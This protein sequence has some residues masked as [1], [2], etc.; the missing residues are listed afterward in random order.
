MATVFSNIAAMSS[1][2]STTECSVKCRGRVLHDE[3]RRL[4]VGDVVVPAL[5]DGDA[6]EQVVAAV[7]RLAELQDVA[8]AGQLDAELLADGAGAAVAAD[9]V[10]RG[11]RS[12]SCRASLISAV[13]DWASCSND[14]N[15]QP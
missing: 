15:S 5:A 1:S 9:Q 14:R 6:L 8:F 10:F 13:T 7:Q 3:L 12:R 11:D 4:V 2:F